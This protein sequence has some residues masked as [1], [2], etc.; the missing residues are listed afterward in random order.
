MADLTFETTDA[1]TAQ[2]FA[3]KWW[4][5]AKT[6]SFFYSQGFVGPNSEQDI[7]VEIPD[8]MQNQGYQHTFGQVRE[9]SGGGISGDNTMEGNEEVPDVFDDAITLD[10][11]RNAVRSGGKLSEQ[12]PSDKGLRGWA[13]VVLQRWMA[14]T[15]DQDTFD[16]L[17]NSL[18]KVIYGGDATTTATIEA[19]DYMTLALISQAVTYSEKANPEIIGKMMDG[20]VVFPCVMAPDQKHDLTQRDAEWKQTQRE[21]D[22]RGRKNLLFKRAMG[23]HRGCVMHYH[24]RVA[25]A[26]TWGSGSN[27]NGATALFMGVGAGAIAYAK[28]KIWTEKT[29]DYKNKVGFCIG[30][31]YGVTKAVFNSADNAVVG[32]RTYRTSN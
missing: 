10:Q 15:I 30:A 31:I 4:I 11:K 16:A 5:Q 2:T 21:A 23:I 26:T 17:G 3:R 20:D 14:R 32:I 22:I 8:L 29:F 7:I 6:S 24:K 28:K 13:T 18:T 9:L 27:L 25:T 12:Y 19:G 1:V